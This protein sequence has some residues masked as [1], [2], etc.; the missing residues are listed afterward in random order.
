MRGAETAGA[1]RFSVSN[2]IQTP[3][4]DKRMPISADIDACVVITRARIEMFANVGRKH[5]ICRKIA[6]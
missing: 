2:L 5:R 4:V 3:S 1:T 6:H